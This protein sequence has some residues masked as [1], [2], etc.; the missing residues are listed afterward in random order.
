MPIETELLRSCILE[1]LR[2]KPQT[3]FEDLK[4]DV[5]P[6]ARDRGFPVGPYTY[7]S[8][9]GAQITIPEVNARYVQVAG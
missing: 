5:A 3:Q 1:A 4:H 8:T 2:R 7:T 6:I 9:L